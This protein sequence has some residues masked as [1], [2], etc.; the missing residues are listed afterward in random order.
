MSRIVL[1]MN[2]K[3]GAGKSTIVFL[4]ATYLSE[5]IKVGVFDADPQGSLS[6]LSNIISDFEVSNDW[7]FFKKESEFDIILIDTPPYLSSDLKKLIPV[8]DLIIIPTKVGVLDVMAISATINLVKNIST[9]AEMVIIMNMVKPNTTLTKEV[10][11]K[12]NSYNVPVS[13]IFI[14]DLVDITR[15]FLVQGVHRN[16]KALL[17]FQ[18]LTNLILEKVDLKT[19]N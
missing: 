7:N 15:S 5:N 14:S 19:I 17:Q 10:T 16:E 1:I 4:A 12:L 9:K 11:Q 18:L 3:G 2:Q 13:E 6:Q 8:A